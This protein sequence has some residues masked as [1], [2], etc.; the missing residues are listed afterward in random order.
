MAR[1]RTVKP[2]FFRHE[3]LQD[4]EIANPGSY[5]MM[6]FAG[7]WGHC[8]SKG[9]FEWRPRQLKLDILPFLPF[10]MEDTLAILERADMVIRY[11]VDGREYGVIPSFEKHQRLSGK[12]LTE[13]ERFPMPTGEATVKQQGS[14]GE[15]PESQEGKGKERKRKGRDISADS[16]RFDARAYLIERLVPE[17][18]TDDW[19]TLRKQKRAAP[20]QTAI[21]G[22][23]A[24]ANKAGIALAQVLALCCQRGWQGFKAE[25]ITEQQREGFKTL[26]QERAD[27]VAILTGKSSP[28]AQVA[29][30]P[31]QG[32]LIDG[33]ARRVG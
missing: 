25:W 4:L 3:A 26:G 9:R 33:E 12:E 17:S 29:Q 22:I 24:E 16:P 21:D 30:I 31:A 13:G 7:L 2:E 19:L 23:H 5:P 10:D 6:V 11:S 18:V 28:S 1:I 15:I 8:D 14:D 20:T 32:Q 27:T